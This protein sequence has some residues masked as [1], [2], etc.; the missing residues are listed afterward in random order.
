MDNEKKKIWFISKYAVNPYYGNPTRQYFISKYI[1]KKGFE[2]SLISSQSSN[3]KEYKYQKKY[4]ELTNEENLFCFVLKGPRIN[5]GFSYLRLWSWL[6]FEYYVL[7]LTL[8]NKKIKNPDVIIVSSLSLL[9][10]CS[11]ILLKWRYNSKLILEIRDIWPLTLI[12]IGDYNKYN[13]LILILGIIEKIGYSTSDAIIGTMPNLKEHVSNVLKKNKKIYCVPQGYDSK[14]L[15]AKIS[16]DTKNKIDKIKLGKFNVAYSGTIGK[17][18]NIDLIL[19]TATKLMDKAENIHFYLVGNGPL[20]EYYINK[21]VN[22]NNVTFIEAVNQIDLPQFLSKFDL[23]I[24][25]VGNKSIYR[26][27]ISPN[28]IVQYM[29]SGRPILFSYNGYKSFIKE[30]EYSFT[31]GANDSDL[32]SSKIIEILMIDKTNLHLM[33]IKGK[34]IVSKYYTFDYLSD[35]YI[36]IIKSI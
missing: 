10:I 5:L 27:G 31:I 14:V 7:R 12:E 9:T 1:S 13:P 34:E 29:R 30:E 23:L 33:G 4:F 16:E 35:I 21:S 22:I 8:F 6:V 32:M 28:K 2:V 15:E 18:N 36:N 25:P 11:G 19:E 24:C 17:S 20:K 26:Y 3:I